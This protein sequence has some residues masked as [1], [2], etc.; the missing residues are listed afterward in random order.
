ME[1]PLFIDAEP[2]IEVSHFTPKGSAGQISLASRACRALKLHDRNQG[3]VIVIEDG[4]LIGFVDK[5]IQATLKDQVIEARRKAK[6]F[7]DQA[8]TEANKTIF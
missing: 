4:I 5:D 8:R 6:E 3:L 7:I 2:V 1:N